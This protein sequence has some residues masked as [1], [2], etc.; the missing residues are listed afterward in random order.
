MKKNKISYIYKEN[1]KQ[2]IF[3]RSLLNPN[4]YDMEEY[5]IKYLNILSLIIN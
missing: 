4:N 1:Q 3:I 5:L 2:S